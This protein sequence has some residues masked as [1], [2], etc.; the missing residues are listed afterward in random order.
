MPNKIGRQNNNPPNLFRQLLLIIVI[1]IYENAAYLVDVREKEINRL[2]GSSNI[3][4]LFLY[5]FS[6]D[7]R[8]VCFSKNTANFSLLRMRLTKN[9]GFGINKTYQIV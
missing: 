1:I 2:S 8:L 4:L 7:A 9:Q 5:N 6:I 3:G